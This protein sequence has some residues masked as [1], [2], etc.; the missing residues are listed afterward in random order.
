MFNKVLGIA[1]NCST[2]FAFSHMITLDLQ[3]AKD[4]IKSACISDEWDI[5]AAS[6]THGD[7]FKELVL[8][9]QPRRTGRG[10]PERPYK[11]WTGVP[12]LIELVQPISD[13]IHKTEADCALLS[14]GPA[15]FQALQNHVLAFG[16][17]Y[18]DDPSAPDY[19][20]LPAI[21]EARMLK[22]C[23]I[24]AYAAFALDPLYFDVDASGSW[25]PALCR[26]DDGDLEGVKTYYERFVEQEQI[27]ALH[28]EL[29]TLQL[30]PLPKKFESL[31]KVCSSRREVDGK[32]IKIIITPASSRRGLWTKNLANNGFPLLALCADRLLSMHATSAA[33][34]RNWSVW[35]HIFTKYRTRLGLIK[36]EMLVIIRGNSET[37][38]ITDGDEF[39]E[40]I[41]LEMLEEILEGGEEDLMGSLVVPRSSSGSWQGVEARAA[42]PS[43]AY[44]IEKNLPEFG[45]VTGERLWGGSDWSSAYIYETVS[46]KHLFVKTAL[47]R[48]E[49]MFKGEALGLQAMAD[50]GSVRIP[51]Q[52]HYGPLEGPGR[53]GSFIVMEA[54][55]LSGRCDQ[56]ELGRQIALM[57]LATPT[58]TNAAAG[59]FGFEVDN[60]IGGTSQPNGW[61]DS[62][63]EFFRERRLKHQLQLAGDR[64]LSDL[65][66][67]LLPNL[68]KFFE[69]AGP[70]KPSILHGDLWSGNIAA[71][72]RRPVIFDPACYYGHHEAEWGMDWC[73]G[74]GGSFWTAYHE[75]IPR[76]PGFDDRHALYTLYHMLNHYN[77]FGS[78]YRGQCTSIMR[79]LVDKL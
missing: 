75:V 77:M 58:D 76:A 1:S 25:T 18:K 45:K 53:R 59:K 50:T 55:N 73:A 48:D 43:A 60:T 14:Q 15:I 63:V 31:Y 78:G 26:L 46:G 72:D 54:L 28:L 9:Y 4:A 74:L 32:K 71:A 49:S 8:E 69:G 24:A 44:W 20:D 7:E 52:H 61:M 70:I 36:G 41:S 37:V 79:R 47:G 22:H 23:P 27:E 34:E 56:A 13:A 38:I 16:D 6:S 17:K 2:R 64:Q 57:H 35:G 42:P 11:F 3:E 19:A 10:R 40:E 39:E 66:A 67:K 65:G 12:R 33:S 21:F 62:W 5:A 51:K 29:A 68:E 30:E